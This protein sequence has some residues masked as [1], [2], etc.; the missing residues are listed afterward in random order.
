M[1]GLAIEI[2][3][4][5]RIPIT[6][7]RPVIKTLTEKDGNHMTKANDKILNQKGSRKLAK[8]NTNSPKESTSDTN[9]F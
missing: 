8:D 2:L 6:L 5:R 7:T 4:Q 3:D 9:S 1:V